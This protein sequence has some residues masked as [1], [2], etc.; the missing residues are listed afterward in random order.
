MT[1]ENIKNAEEKTNSSRATSRNDERDSK[2]EVTLPGGRKIIRRPTEHLGEG[3]LR[4]SAAQKVGFTRR[5]ASDEIDG[6]I[7]SYINIGWIP[8]TDDAGSQIQPVRGGT[9]KSGGEYKMFLLEI[10][11]KELERLKE[12]NKELDSS[13]KAIENQ[14]KW[15]EGQHIEG[16]THNPSGTPN[17]IETRDVKAP[18]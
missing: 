2:L 8:A 4:L 11:T 10:P 14:N 17:K 18:K 9:R 7:Q 15:L 6:K 1:R 12:K 16:F 3:A 13:V 5:W